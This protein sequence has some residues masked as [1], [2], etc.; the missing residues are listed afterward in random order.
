VRRN[1]FISSPLCASGGTLAQENDLLLWPDSGESG[2]NKLPALTSGR[3]V[4][5][6]ARSSQGSVSGLSRALCASLRSAQAMLAPSLALSVDLQGAKKG[7]SMACALRRLAQSARKSPLTLPW[8]G[9]RTVLRSS[10]S[11]QGSG[12]DSRSRAR[13]EHSRKRSVFCGATRPLPVC[14][15]RTGIPA[16]RQRPRRTP[17]RILKKSLTR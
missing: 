10:R 14:R 2:H 9:W 7:A 8:S 6:V 1:G 3:R 15:N 5:A 16:N 11:S 17:K 12:T 4:L 13:R